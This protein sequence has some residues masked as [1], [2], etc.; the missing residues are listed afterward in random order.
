MHTQVALARSLD[1]LEGATAALAQIECAAVETET[2]VREARRDLDDG[3][4][5]AETASSG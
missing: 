3:S 5:S 1:T 2:V 4:G